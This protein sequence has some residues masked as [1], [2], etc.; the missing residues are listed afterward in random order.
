MR[1]AA[2]QFLG[3]PVVVDHR[4]QRLQRR[5]VL[6]ALGAVR[7]ALGQ[8]VGGLRGLRGD[9][10]AGLVQVERPLDQ[11]LALIIRQRNPG[12]QAACAC[13]RLRE[14]VVKLVARADQLFALAGEPL[15][16]AVQRLRLR[17][18]KAKHADQ[19]GDG[20]RRVVPRQRMAGARQHGGQ[21][22]A[23]RCAAWHSNIPLW[24]DPFPTKVRL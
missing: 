17:G 7:Y 18:Q 15:D 2:A 21:T 6:A 8:G 23:H 5:A 10:H 14:G 9:R 24:P 13:Q 11:Q 16:G 22:P 12:D 1:E 19:P 4:K 3:G 20:A